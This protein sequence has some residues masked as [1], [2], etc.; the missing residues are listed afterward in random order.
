MMCADVNMNVVYSHHWYSTGCCS[1]AVH[2]RQTNIHS[3]RTTKSCATLC[4]RS[5]KAFVGVAFGLEY[6]VLRTRLT[7]DYKRTGVA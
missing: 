7:Q 6:I 4:T 2:S 5:C 3:Q 1:D